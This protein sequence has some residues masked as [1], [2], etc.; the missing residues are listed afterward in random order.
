MI[1][2]SIFFFLA[3]V[4]SLGL[5]S[6]GS[7]KLAS[8]EDGSGSELNVLLR[9]DSDQ[10]AWDVDELFANSNVSLSD[11]NSGMMDG[12]SELSL[13]NESLESS[14]HDLRRG[15]TQDVIELSFI[16]L[17]HSESNHSSDKS[18]AFEE[19]SGVSLFQGQ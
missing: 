5:L 10:V 19:S 12:V 4:T 3:T 1:T 16:L 14:L 9:A 18:I 15:K 7:A 2:A 6:L 13:G 8:L 11:E 17:Q